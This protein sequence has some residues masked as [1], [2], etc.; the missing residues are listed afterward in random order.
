[1][2]LSLRNKPLFLY[3]GEEPAD[4]SENYL[5][6]GRKLTDAL[7]ESNDKAC[8]V[9]IENASELA[10]RCIFNNNLV[11]I[12]G[13]QI[14]DRFGKTWLG[15]LDNKLGDKTSL[16]KKGTLK[17][18]QCGMIHN[19]DDDSSHFGCFIVSGDTIFIYDSMSSPGNVDAFQAGI[20]RHFNTKGY[21]FVFVMRE[22]QYQETG[23]FYGY[24]PV[25]DQ[26]LLE[27]LP[28]NLAEEYK[29]IRLNESTESQNHFCYMWSL[30]NLIAHYKGI[31]PDV[32]NDDPLG[33]IKR[34]MYR[35]I[36]NQKI[37]H[38]PLFDA[39]FLKCWDVRG[40]LSYYGVEYYVRTI[41]E[42]KAVDNIVDAF[43]LA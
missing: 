36:K 1:M 34:F 5:I 39:W 21:E 10:R 30:Y 37:Q 31:D 16:K 17:T 38:R 4:E 24:L 43:S 22:L 32:P 27:E 13:K 20:Q 23:G 12:W 26:I 42:P 3:K 28:E 2:K 18:D 25:A 6:G 15:V 19:H 40:G 11:P 41:P 29:T 9:L 7:F 8:L 14:A 33:T 35:V